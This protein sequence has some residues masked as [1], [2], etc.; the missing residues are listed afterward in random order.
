MVLIRGG[1]KRR[2]DTYK[3][4]SASFLPYVVYLVNIFMYYVGML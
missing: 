2:I 3:Y 1:S 4:V